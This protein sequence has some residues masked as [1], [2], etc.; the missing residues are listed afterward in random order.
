MHK[1]SH[2]RLEFALSLT[3][4]MQGY[5]LEEVFGEKRELSLYNRKTNYSDWICYL[6]VGYVN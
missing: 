1:L 4:G 6:S 5:Y 3:G 2:S